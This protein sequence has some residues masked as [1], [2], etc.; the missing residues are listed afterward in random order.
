MATAD[1]TITVDDST[2]SVVPGTDDTYTITV[3]NNGPDAVT[4]ASVSDL[5]PAGVTAATWMFT[6][7]TGSG[8]V[9]GPPSGSGALAT[10]VDLPQV[11]DSVTFTF[12]AAINPSATGTIDNTATVS[13]PAG[14]TDTDLTNNSATDTDA[15]T[16]EADLAITKTDG[17][18]T[19][20]PGSSD[21]YTIIVSNNGSST[22]V[23]APVTDIFPAAM[24][25]VSWTAVASAGSSVGAA[26]GVGNIN[27]F[28]TLLPGGAATFTAVGQISSS[29]TGS[30]ANT[31][32]VATPAGATD[33]DLTNNDATD[34]DILTATADLSV[35]K[36]VSNATPNVGDTITYTVTLSDQGP[37]NATNVVVTDLL[38][39]GLTFVSATPSQGA[40]S[41]ASGVWTVGTVSTSVVQTLIINATVASPDALTNT[42]TI[43]FADQVDPN[44]ANNTA[45]ATE[46]PQQADLSLSKSVNNPT[47]NVGETIAFIVTL[48]DL[49]PDNATGVQVFDLLPAGLTFA[50]ATT[51]QGTYSFGTGFW[52]VGTVSPGGQQTLII[53]AV[54]DIPGALTNT[55]AISHADQFDPDPTNNSASATETPPADLLVLK[56]V[57]NATPNVG[58]TIIFTVT[59]SDQGPNDA[60][61]VQVTDLLPAGLTFVSAAPSQGTYTSGTGLWDVGTVSTSVVQTLIINA[62]VASP[63]ALTNT[64][65][66]SP[67]GQFDPNTA[68]NTASAT[69]T[70]QQAD[71][72][73][74]KSVNNPTPN[75][76]ETIAFIVTLSDLGPDNA[77]GVQVFDLLPAGLTFA[78]ATTTQ[79]TYSFGTGFWDVGTVSPGGQQT[80]IIDAVVDIP[81]ALTNTA[82]ISHAD[83]FDPDPTNNSASATETQQ[84]DLSVTITDA[85]TTLV[86]GTSNTYTITVTNNGTDPVSSFNLIDT[87]PDALLNATFGSPSAGSYDPASGLWSALSLGSGQSVFITLSGVIGIA[88]GTLSNT[89]TVSPSAGLVDTNPGNNVA[90]DSDTLVLFS[91]P[92]P[93]PP[94][95]TSAN[96]I[97]RRGDG[98]YAIYDIGNNA[99][100]DAHPLAQ[101]GSDWQFAGFNGS[102]PSDMMLRNSTSGAFQVYDVSDNNITGTAALGAVGLNWQVAGFG[103]FSSSGE[104]DMMLRDAN[105]GGFQAYDIA[106]NQITGTA[107]VGT[108]GL[109]WQVGGFGNFSSRAGASDMILRNTTTGGLQVYNIDSNQ[110]TGTAFMGT[111]GLEWQFSGFGNFSSM[112]GE[113]GMIMRNANTGALVVYDIAN[114]QIT[115]TAFLGT[116][117]LEWQ[118]AGVAPVRGAGTADLVLRN[119]NT[120]AFEAYNIANNQI[121]G[122]ASLGHVGLEWSVGGFAADPPTASTGSAGATAQLVQAMAAFGGGSGTGESL[123][124]VPLSAETSQQPLLTQPHA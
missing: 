115:G 31:A 122:A 35:S 79:G 25:A 67:A 114:N 92:Y 69:E 41:S 17:V 12:T 36:T 76:G 105:T 39:A 64:A 23:A 107:F 1:L 84:A 47:P 66:I 82:A 7:S 46:T 99:T 96:M 98:L 65:A 104:T 3:T 18:T 8:S 34:T 57:S 63:D 30:L 91:S 117:G 60:T 49:G 16:P 11:G 112:P 103:N 43:S 6:G 28:V 27:T 83:Q 55:A 9:S 101:V 56:S 22:A 109:D 74:S 72:S 62:T 124:T 20:V 44:T 42:G 15:L 119:V 78:G 75:V 40:Y 118:F 123:N 24:T 95:A 116:V 88:T 2:T 38:P 90:T 113:T 108:V 77:T 33:P 70:P 48:S 80:L 21:T 58:D 121:V 81:G 13:L 89:V 32:S 87:I 14:T 73:L 10:T 4:G 53:D 61:N 59:L 86:P 71:L 93:P 106:N 110:I 45:S 50:G 52:D 111:I 37:D 54:V 19:V 29:A 68:N 100:L 102:D 120:G 97:L 51:T 94:P 85:A 26:S 5:L